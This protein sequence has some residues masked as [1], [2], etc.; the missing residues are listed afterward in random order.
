MLAPRAQTASPGL[1]REIKAAHQ[2]SDWLSIR[3][4]S[5]RIDKAKKQCQEVPPPIS[6]RAD[7]Q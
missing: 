1:L 3:N 5:S 7:Q 4:L 2:I 6:E